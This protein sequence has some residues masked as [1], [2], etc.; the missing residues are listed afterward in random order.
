[1]L[2]VVTSNT[3]NATSDQ[4]LPFV[5]LRDIA[6]VGGFTAQ[7]LVIVGEPVAADADH[8]GIDRR[9]QSQSRQGQHGLG[10]APGTVSHLAIE[11]LKLS[12]GIG[13]T[14]V[15][16]RGGA[17]M[18]ID[19]FGGAVPSGVRRPAQFAAPH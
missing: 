2:L 13:L 7:P 8:A 14:H 5:F 19:I 16:Y 9:S 4:S 11:L 17:P 10:S 1:M 12:A 18:V 3:V 15:P 6:P